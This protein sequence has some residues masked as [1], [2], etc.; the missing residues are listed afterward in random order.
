MVMVMMVMMMVMAAPMMVVVMMVVSET[1]LADGFLGRTGI[2]GLQH[3]DRV[4]NRFKQI[5]VARRR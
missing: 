3:G 4:R 2:I 5:P 1:G